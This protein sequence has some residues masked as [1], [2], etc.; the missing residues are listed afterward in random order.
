MATLAGD[1]RGDRTTS[2]VTSGKR[3][4]WRGPES[5]PEPEQ[6][7]RGAGTT[8]PF[9]PVYPLGR[10]REER[11]E[12]LKGE[13]GESGSITQLTMQA[14]RLVGR[15]TPIS[16]PRCSARA[17]NASGHLWPRVREGQSE[18]R[19]VSEQPLAVRDRG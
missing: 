17:E 12:S 2:A 9:R 11:K 5:R 3:G 10:E 14:E 1:V 8:A 18:R 15:A 7:H 16:T 19:G 13:S 4:Q 6:C